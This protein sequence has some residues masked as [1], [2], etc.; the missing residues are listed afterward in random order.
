M[1]CRYDLHEVPVTFIV[2]RQEDEVEVTS[3][4]LVLE[5]MVIVAGHIYLTSDDRLDLGKFLRYL[6]EFLD[7]IHI[8]MV[9]DGQSRHAE[10]LGTL[11][12][13]GNRRLAV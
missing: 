10:F 5:L 3:V 8:S 4:I 9:C 6:Q 11:K 12:K 7:T 2:L 1:A 13:A